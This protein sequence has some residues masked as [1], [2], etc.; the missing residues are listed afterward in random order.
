[1]STATLVD[2]SELISE[3]D[4]EVSSALVDARL[5]AHP[6]PDFPVRLPQTLEQAYAIQARSISRWP[7]EL[8]GWKV[9][10]LADSDRGRLGAERLAA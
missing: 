9:A 10:R 5:D 8:A 7:D 3:V 2:T 6:L 4:E 1:M